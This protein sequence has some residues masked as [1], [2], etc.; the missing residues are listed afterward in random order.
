MKTVVTDVVDG[1]VVVV[2]DGVVVVVVVAVEEQKGL[3]VFLTGQEML[4]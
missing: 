3:N 4:V 2:I 1:V